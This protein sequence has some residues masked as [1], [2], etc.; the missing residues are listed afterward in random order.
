MVGNVLSVFRAELGVA[1]AKAVAGALGGT[2]ASRPDVLAATSVGAAVRIVDIDLDAEL[3]AWLSA[4]GI[5]RGERVV[6]LRRAAFGGPLHIRIAS[7]GEFALN[8]AL[9]RSIRI[10][11]VPAKSCRVGA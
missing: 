6:V 1:R 2:A 9:A 3:V 10:A 4:V 5:G 11:L 8:L 7:G